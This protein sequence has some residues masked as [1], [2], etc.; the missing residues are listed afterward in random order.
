MNGS[1]PR[2]QS[3]VAEVLEAPVVQVVHGRVL[4]STRRLNGLA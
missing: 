1:L 3:P 4:R 2:C